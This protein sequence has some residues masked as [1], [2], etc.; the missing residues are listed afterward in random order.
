MNVYDEIKCDNVFTACD[1]GSTVYSIW[2]LR[3]AGLGLGYSSGNAYIQG[4]SVG[5]A[6]IYEYLIPFGQTIYF[7][8]ICN[9][10]YVLMGQF[11]P[12]GRFVDMDRSNNVTWFTTTLT[13]Q[14]P[15]CCQTK[16]GI[17]TVNYSAGL[18][19]FIDRSVA[20]PAQWYWTF[21]DGDTST[22]QFPYHQYS[23]GGAHTVTLTT[24][25]AQGCGGRDTFIVM[26][27]QNVGVAPVSADV[28]IS[29]FP[30][31]SSGSFRLSCEG[32]MAHDVHLSLYNV[33]GQSVDFTYHTISSSAESRALDLSVSESGTYMLRVQTGGKTYYRKLL[34][35]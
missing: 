15:G 8:S 16:F 33:L 24:L 27:P 35:L 28:A 1:Y 31:P 5:F 3:N 20:M 30:N 25:S 9:G 32:D 23:T 6:D 29:V 2:G 7:D 34:K 11:D 12:D 18:F 13:K 22:E 10:D 21:G 19:H 14:T 26:V 4:I 17:D